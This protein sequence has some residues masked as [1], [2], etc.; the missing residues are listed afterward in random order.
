MAPWP[1]I[2]RAM[3]ELH[4]CLLAEMVYS[5]PIRDARVRRCVFFRQSLDFILLGYA[6]FHQDLLQ[7]GISL[8]EDS[9]LALCSVICKYALSSML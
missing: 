4:R 6:R 3:L 9:V 8:K 1:R 5:I 7:T 2:L